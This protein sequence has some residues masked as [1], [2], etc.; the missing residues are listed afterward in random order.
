M[1]EQ[2]DGEE[3]EK[4]RVLFSQVEINE[5]LVSLFSSLSLLRSTPTSF[6]LAQ[7]VV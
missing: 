3:N 7:N 6:P 4:D 2:G 1:G 5:F